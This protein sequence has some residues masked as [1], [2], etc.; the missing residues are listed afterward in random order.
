MVEIPNESNGLGKYLATSVK[1][2]MSYLCM[3][4]SELAR[5]V[6][7]R[8]KEPSK[9]KSTTLQG[10]IRL[11]TNGDLDYWI[12]TTRE[13]THESAARRRLKTLSFILDEL[14][15]KED[16]ELIKGLRENYKD[17]RYPPLMD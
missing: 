2:A 1:Q 12:G 10:W 5:R 14:D 17:F 9:I 15:I 4:R 13:Y 16:D 7:E 6:E 8:T 11:V 3:T